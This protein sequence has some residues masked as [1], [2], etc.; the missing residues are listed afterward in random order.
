[1][2]ILWRERE[3]GEGEEEE[4]EE[5]E[6]IR[7]K[8]KKRIIRIKDEKQEKKGGGWDNTLRDRERKLCVN[9]YIV[10]QN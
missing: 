4:E 7:R 2:L 8:I 10:L 1:M 9:L 5:E 3:R 6:E